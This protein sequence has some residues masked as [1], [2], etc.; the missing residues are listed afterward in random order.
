M[1]TTIDSFT[2]RRCDDDTTILY[3]KIDEKKKKNELTARARLCAPTRV[4][5]V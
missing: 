5:G 3:D 2:V 1:Y 4:Y